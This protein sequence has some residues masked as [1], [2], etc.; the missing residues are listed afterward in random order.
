MCHFID[1]NKG[2]VRTVES[3]TRHTYIVLIFKVVCN[4]SAHARNVSYA[5]IS[6]IEHFGEKAQYSD[7]EYDLALDIGLFSAKKEVLERKF[8][9]YQN[10]ETILNFKDHSVWRQLL[11]PLKLYGEEYDDSALH[12]LYN[13]DKK[14][15]RY[16]FSVLCRCEPK[17]RTL[18]FTGSSNCGKSI[19][20]NAILKPIAPAYIQRDGGTNVH[21]LENLYRKSVI[22]WEEP[23]IHMSNIE[24]VKLILGGETLIINRKNKQLIERPKGPAVI[25]TTNKEFWHYEPETL[26]NRINIYYFTKKVS[27]YIQTTITDAQLITYLCNVYDGRH[28]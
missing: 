4:G 7:Y 5:I 24:D 16:W 15:V 18:V 17:K 9:E 8:E 14:T 13:L 25:I 6:M 11:N 22:L 21:W 2:I 23:S 20:A 19:L 28:H 1:N 3:S 27:D 10:L 12:N 26:L